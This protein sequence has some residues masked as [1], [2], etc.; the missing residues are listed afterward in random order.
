MNEQQMTE[1]QAAEALVSFVAARKAEGDSD[2]QIKRELVEQGID[3]EVAHAAVMAV[4]DV[5]RRSGYRSSRH[6]ESSS[7]G[8]AGMLVGAVVCAIG[9]I[10]TIGS[11]A[12]AAPG[13]TYV[14]AYGA[15]IWGA[16]RFFQG[17]S[18]AG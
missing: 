12:A 11:F 5:P 8:G 14:V 15:I 1:E 13:G 18:S 3:I 4:D 9:V 6:R 7:G 16:I 2:G 17:M 10:V